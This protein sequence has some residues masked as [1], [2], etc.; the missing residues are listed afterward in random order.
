MIIELTFCEHLLCIGPC[1]RHFTCTNL[2]NP[3][4]NSLKQAPE[5]S[6]PTREGLKCDGSMAMA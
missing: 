3:H 2:F 1:A 6:H 5:L 4:D